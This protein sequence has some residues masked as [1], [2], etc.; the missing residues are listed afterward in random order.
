MRVIKI[1]SCIKNSINHHATT[2]F[3]L[4]INIVSHGDCT[5]TIWGL[6]TKTLAKEI[7]GMHL[8]L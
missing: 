6:T 5:S 1:T 4:S 3:S 2:F 7:Q 8:Y